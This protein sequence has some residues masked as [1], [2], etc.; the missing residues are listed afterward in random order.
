MKSKKVDS[1]DWS[2]SERVWNFKAGKR[3]VKSQSDYFSA[4]KFHTLSWILILWVLKIT[5]WIFNFNS[6]VQV[7]FNTYKT[8]E[9]TTYICVKLLKTVTVNVLRIR[10]NRKISFGI[11]NVLKD[12]GERWFFLLPGD[13][14]KR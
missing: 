12:S 14:R 6:K 5:L 13:A 7:I 8:N 2:S 3:N 1:K 11:L 9:N 4:L 10:D